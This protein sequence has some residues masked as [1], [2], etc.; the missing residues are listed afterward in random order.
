V[1]VDDAKEFQ[2]A[3]LRLLADEMITPSLLARCTALLQLLPNA[4]IADNPGPDL[5]VIR[6]RRL[7]D[8][9]VAHNRLALIDRPAH[10]HNILAAGALI[11]LVA[12][13]SER[14][15]A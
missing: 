6:L 1:V 9:V 14:S 10:T 15:V 7:L 13:V 12:D 3:E 11:G 5:R 2:M 8:E 4:V